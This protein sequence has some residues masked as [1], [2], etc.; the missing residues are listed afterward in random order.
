[1]APAQELTVAVASSAWY[2]SCGGDL[3]GASSREGIEFDCGTR[4]RLTADH[5]HADVLLLNLGHSESPSKMLPTIRS[6]SPNQTWISCSK[7]NGVT[8][9][10]PGPQRLR[11]MG[12]DYQMHIPELEFERAYA[13]S[14]HSTH[15]RLNL[16]T[17]ELST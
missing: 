14:C 3:F 16:G 15:P 12:V 6:K 7:E 5:V 4:I 11:Q 2:H 8:Y 13:V 9:W 1:V 10:E 17:Q